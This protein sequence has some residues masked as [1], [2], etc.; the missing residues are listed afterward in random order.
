M[1]KKRG[2]WLVVASRG[3]ARGARSATVRR[4]DMVFFLSFGFGEAVVLVLGCGVG[5]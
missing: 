3:G 5:F 2:E 1:E 4:R